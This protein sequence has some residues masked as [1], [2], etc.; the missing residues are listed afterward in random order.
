MRIGDLLY[1]AP[2]ISFDEI[3]LGGPELPSQFR[4]RITGFYL[5]PAEACANLGH[6]FA[7]GVLLVSSIDALARIRFG[8]GVGAR[9]KRF[10]R[11]ELQSFQDDGLSE[12][13]YDEFRNGLVHE[14]RLKNGAQFSLETGATVA[15]L[16]GLLLINPTYLAREVRTALDSYVALLEQDAGELGKLAATLTQDLAD[17]FRIARE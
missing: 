14:A 9:F 17:D 8:D 5:D 10:A 7:A 2:G 1:F 16:D 12:R 4:R 15:Q 3:D 6:V 11:E 13:F